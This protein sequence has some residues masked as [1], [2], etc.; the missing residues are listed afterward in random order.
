MDAW[1]ED[2]FKEAYAFL[3]QSTVV[4]MVNRGMVALYEDVSDIFRPVELLAQVH[5]SVLIQYPTEDFEAA[6]RMAVK[7]GWDYLRPKIQYGQ[8]EFFIETDLKIGRDWGHMVEVDLPNDPDKVATNLEEA[9]ES[10]NAKKA[11]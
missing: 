2:L 3:P 1:G 4:D 5:D 10:I 11:A 7:L 8:R 6:G 9:W